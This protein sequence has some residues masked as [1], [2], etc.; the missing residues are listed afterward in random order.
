M[1]QIQR[2]SVSHNHIAKEGCVLGESVDPK[3]KYVTYADYIKRV[4]ELEAPVSDEE[5]NDFFDK[6]ALVGARRALDALLASRAGKEKDD[7]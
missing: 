6:A 2:W 4:A 5:C 7:G 3:G 1:S